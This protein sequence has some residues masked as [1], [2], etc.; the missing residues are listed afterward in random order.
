MKTLAS[1]ESAKAF[2]NPSALR[3]IELGIVELGDDY[4]TAK[5]KIET[6]YEELGRRINETG[7]L[8]LFVAL[9]TLLDDYR[10]RIGRT[11]GPRVPAARNLAQYLRP[12]DRDL[13][14]SYELLKFERNEIAHGLFAIRPLV[15]I[16]IEEK[17]ILESILAALGTVAPLT[18]LAEFLQGG[19][20]R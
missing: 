15:A 14:D 18:P 17:Q 4:P 12:I 7:F 11:R 6:F 8:E 5:R 1:E 9:E 19:G 10:K 2:A 20:Q 13:A 16:A 3:H